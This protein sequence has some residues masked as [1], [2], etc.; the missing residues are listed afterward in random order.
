MTGVLYTRAE[1]DLFAIK[2]SETGYTVLSS[3]GEESFFHSAGS[4]LRTLSRHSRAESWAF[5]QYFRQ[6]KYRPLSERALDAPLN[7]PSATIHDLFGSAP[8]TLLDPF[9]N[10]GSGLVTT[11][12]GRVSVTAGS[13]NDRALTVLPSRHYGIDLIG[14][15]KEVAKLFYK[16]Y[17][18]RVARAGYDPEEVLQEVYKGL[19]IRNAGTCPW[20]GEKST[21]GHYVHMVAGCI[22][23]NF[24]RRENR[25]RQ[26]EQIGI[27]SADGVMVDVASDEAVIPVKE[28]GVGG[29]FLEDESAVEDYL[30]YVRAW[31]TPEARAHRDV[32]QLM[33]EGVNRLEASRRLGLPVAL[34]S[35]LYGTFRGLLT[36][37]NST[38][39][40]VG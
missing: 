14:R 25:R 15:S 6:G 26:V 11:V 5:D 35:R 8:V 10:R 12:A 16:G 29:V 4:L 27:G 34:V 28:G 36:E 7:R 24:F 38:P 20:D 19:L 22:V 3:D 37:W 31:G 17:G 1:D 23:S 39:C 13:G 30:Q 32:A 21:F 18:A 2:G 40:R 33:C 9:V